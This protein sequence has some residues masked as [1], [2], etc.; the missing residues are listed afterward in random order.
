MVYL[1]LLTPL[2]GAGVI[3][4]EEEENIQSL[5]KKRGPKHVSPE[6]PQRLTLNN[7]YSKIVSDET[8][9]ISDRQRPDKTST[10]Y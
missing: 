9:P 6:N 10:T 7:C 5:W 8:W 4:P 3:K 2:T 1:Y